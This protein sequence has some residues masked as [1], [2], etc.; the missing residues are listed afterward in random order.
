MDKGT[1]GGSFKFTTTLVVM[2]CQLLKCVPHVPCFSRYST[3]LCVCGVISIWVY[4]NGPIWFTICDYKHR[5]ML[6]Y[7][8]WILGR[9]LIS[10]A[11]SFVVCSSLFILLRNQVSCVVNPFL[12]YH[13]LP[14]FPD[15]RQLYVFVVW[16]R[17][18]STLTDPFDSNKNNLKIDIQLV[19]WCFQ[20]R[21][22][23]WTPDDI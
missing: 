15:I 10:G 16:Y 1:T 18:E 12:H 4:L 7:F 13:W 22:P 6:D 21:R 5:D 3:A 19:C 11:P 20:M 2:S 9:L 23:V 14:V 17:F 8:L